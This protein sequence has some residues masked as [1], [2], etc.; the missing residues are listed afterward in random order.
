MVLQQI[1]FYDIIG[2]IWSM[3]YE[4]WIKHIM[5]CV[6][7]HIAA[8]VMCYYPGLVRDKPVG[9]PVSVKLVYW[10]PTTRVFLAQKAN[11]L[12][13]ILMGFHHFKQTRYFGN[14]F[15]K[16]PGTINKELGIFWKYFTKSWWHHDMETL[17]KLLAL[18]GGIHQWLLSFEAFFIVCPNKLLNK[19]SNCQWFKMPWHSFDVIVIFN[20]VLES[21][22]WGIWLHMLHLYC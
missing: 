5:F 7:K 21:E 10:I 17:P 18:C 13:S 22:T 6:Q 12:E 4:A 8:L 19:Q 15:G 2:S 3:V 11:N 20:K 9:A 14:L 16:Q 1:W